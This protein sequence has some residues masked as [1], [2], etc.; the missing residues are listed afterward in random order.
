MTNVKCAD[1]Q[2]AVSH[3]GYFRGSRNKEAE[4]KR[5]EY[6]EGCP[7]HAGNIK[8]QPPVVNVKL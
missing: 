6:K 8:M 2:V 7:S 5:Q 1:H 4:Q 3:D